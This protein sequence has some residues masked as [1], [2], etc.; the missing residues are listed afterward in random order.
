MKRFI[1]NYI[2]FD[3]TQHT[4]SVLCVDNGIISMQP[5]EVETAATL[6]VEGAIVV[7]TVQAVD[8]VSSVLTASATLS[9]ALQSMLPLTA[10]PHPD[11]PKSLL[12]ITFSPK[13]VRH[14]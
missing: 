9:D 7:V 8:E 10:L 4:N 1:S 13:I 3:S 6:Y 14:L 5:F 12:Q 11:S 2:L